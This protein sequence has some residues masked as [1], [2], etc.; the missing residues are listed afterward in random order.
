MLLQCQAPADQVFVRKYKFHKNA[1]LFLTIP[2]ENRI[3]FLWN[4]YFIYDTV[5]KNITEV[6]QFSFARACGARLEA[7]YIILFR[8]KV[9]QCKH[10]RAR[11]VGVN[12]SFVIV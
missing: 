7:Q 12:L 10:S 8:W 2:A 4:K 9:L 5:K 6:A 3:Q 11:E 1:T